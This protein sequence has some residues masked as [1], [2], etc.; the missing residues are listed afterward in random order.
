MIS[1][2]D[3]V[4]YGLDDPTYHFVVAMKDG[5]STELYFSR[6]LSGYYYGYIKG[7]DNYFMISE[8]QIEGLDF[9]EL[10]L[11]DPYICYCYAKNI[12][13]ITGTYGDKSFKLE[14]YVPE[15]YSISD[16]KASVSLD[17]R[18]AKISDSSGR[19]YCSVLF[20]SIACIKI[21]GA[22]SDA[23]VDTSADAE[24]SLT[25][26]DNGYNT[27]VYEFYTR[28]ADSYYVFKDGIY[29]GF[30]VYSKEIFYNAGRDTY[31]YGFWS[32]YEL[33]NVAI[34]DGING[35]YDIPIE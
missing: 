29:T 6:L 10:V 16:D 33:L 32:A 35:I 28:D 20:E 23:N 19:S 17:G 1:D 4:K 9:S 31:S 21:G 3:L 26:L 7:M 13:S 18:N 27:T 2:D 15:G 8:H 12:S 5:S 11:I 25:F 30:Y 24:I 22:E 34:T 14:L